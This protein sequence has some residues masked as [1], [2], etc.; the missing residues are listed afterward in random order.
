MN[1]VTTHIYTLAH[2]VTNEIRY[3][4]KADDMKARFHGHFYDKMNNRKGNWI[5]HLRSQGLSPKI[6]VLDIVPKEDWQY[7]E[8]FYILLLKSWGMRLTNGTHGGDGVVGLKHTEDAKNKVRIANI[9]KKA[10][11]ATKEKMKSSS[12][13]FWLGKKMSESL[14]KKLSLAHKGKKLTDDQKK[15]M[16]RKGVDHHFYGK[17]FT[18]EHKAKLWA[19]RSRTVSD[20]VRKNMSSAA[21]KGWEKRRNKIAA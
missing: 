9:G 17:K 14:R 1:S 4:G 13:R 11:Q 19:T 3:V 2:P 6:E 7:W 5:K 18:E 16:G 10:S 15:N 21:K 8:C 12:S 20:E